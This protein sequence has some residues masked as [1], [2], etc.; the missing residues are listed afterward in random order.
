MRTHPAIAE[1]ILFTLYDRGQSSFHSNIPTNEDEEETVVFEAIQTAAKEQD[2]LSFTYI[3]EGHIV[4][5]WGIAQDIEYWKNG[6]N[7]RKGASWA[8]K[9]VKL[10][11]GIT[12][13]M[14]NHGNKRLYENTTAS[15][16][17]K[18]RKAI[19]RE[20]Q[21]HFKIGFS[22]LRNKDRKTICTGIATLNKWTTS[23]LETWLQ[24]IV[25]LHKRSSAQ[26]LK[27]RF[28][29][30]NDAD[31]NLYIQRAENLKRFSIPKFRRWRLRHHEATVAQYVRSTE[32][33]KRQLKKRRLL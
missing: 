12:R 18:R 1:T 6:N 32:T 28:D 10:L 22:A 3:F 2:Q 23:M 33:L 29:G 20:V 21:T 7:N 11:Y 14:W 16:S 8:K 30:K 19:L 9:L 4:K 25:V 26:N 5:K 27:E 24:H 15:T 31:D 17:L 13:E